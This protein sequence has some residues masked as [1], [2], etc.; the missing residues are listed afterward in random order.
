MAAIFLRF[1]FRVTVSLFTSHNLNDFWFLVKLVQIAP[2]THVERNH[3]LQK[4][5]KPHIGGFDCYS[6]LR[7]HTHPQ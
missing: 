2:V 3:P 1:Q 5:K 4:N 6:I 7:V